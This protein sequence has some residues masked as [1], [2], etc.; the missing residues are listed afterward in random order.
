M[1]VFLWFLEGNVIFSISNICTNVLTSI[2]L[3][4]FVRSSKKR[5]LKIALN[6]TK[7]RIARSHNDNNKG[8]NIISNRVL[9]EHLSQE[10]LPGDV[11]EIEKN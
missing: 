1:A 3:Y 2:I 11:F 9:Q 5:L 6:Q 8:S 10:L 4:L 7:V